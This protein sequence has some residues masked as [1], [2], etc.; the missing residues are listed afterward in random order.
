MKK[1][2]IVCA[3]L[4][5][6]GV[7]CKKLD[8]GG[9]GLCGCSPISVPELV[10]VIKNAD[11]KDMFDDKTA[12]AYA[13]DKV[14]MYRK[15]ETGKIIPLRVTVRPQF[16]YGNETFAFNQIYSNDIAFFAKEL[17]GI[18]YLKLGDRKTYELNAEFN[19]GRYALKKLFADKKELVKDM[20]PVLQFVP[21][22]YITE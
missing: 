16:R 18:I 19:E 15:D 22:F 7:G 4:F 10:L 14:E 17:N 11:G 9:G 5:I 3:V 20:G 2:L 1:F 21:I 8:I 13:K 12:G 6:G